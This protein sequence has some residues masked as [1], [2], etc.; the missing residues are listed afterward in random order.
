MSAVLQIKDLVAETAELKVAAFLQK[1]FQVRRLLEEVRRALSIVSPSGKVSG[2]VQSSI[3]SIPASVSPFS[4]SFHNTFRNH[5]FYI[6]SDNQLERISLPK[7]LHSLFTSTRTGRLRVVSGTT[8]KRIYVSSGIPVYAESSIPDETLGAY[9]IDTKIISANQHEQALAD[10]TRSGRHFGESLLKLAFISPHELYNAMVKHLAEKIVST[11]S[12]KQGVF[13]FEE[14]ESWKDDVI[15]ARMKP[16]RIILDGI[17]RYWSTEEILSTNTFDLRNHCYLIDDIP[18]TEEQ[19]ALSSTEIKVLQLA[20]RKLSVQEI[21]SQSRTDIPVIPIVYALY[22]MEHIGFFQQIDISPTY[23]SN[24]DTETSSHSTLSSFDTSHISTEELSQ[25]LLA[26]YLK[27]KSVD[28]FTLLGVSR[29]ATNEQIDAAFLARQKRYHPNNLVGLRSGLVHEKMEEL[30]IRV[31]T[32]HRTLTDDNLRT[33]YLEDLES[34]A[35]RTMLSQRSKTGKFE[36]LSNKP[37]HEILFDDGFSFLRNGEFERALSL[38]KEA[39]GLFDKPRYS[40]YRAWCLYLVNSQNRNIVEK[41]LTQT[42]PS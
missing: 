26:E 39:E 12:W 22:I 16:G 13:R 42:I 14:Y 35:K 5:P 3:S 31:D 10:M 23:C 41:E 9:L 24:T 34:G 20:R 8:E 11:F 28:Y 6:D 2:D 29:D 4:N 32:A 37:K 19:I 36:T 40:A 33:R 25:K 27:F 21:A 38:F 18:Y 7:V 15:I 1:P 30:Y 17:L